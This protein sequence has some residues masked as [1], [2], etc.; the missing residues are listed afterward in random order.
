MIKELYKQLRLAKA[1]NQETTRDADA[2]F[3]RPDGGSKNLERVPLAK[4]GGKPDTW[5]DFRSGFKAILGTCEPAIE[6][7]RL[8]NTMPEAA[9]KFIMGVT[10]PADTWSVLD[11]QYGNRDMA[12]ALA[13]TNLLALKIPKGPG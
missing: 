8:R 2:S 5:A 1:L 10:E 9:T 3:S 7:L 12:I 6:M 13:I 4:F 11:R